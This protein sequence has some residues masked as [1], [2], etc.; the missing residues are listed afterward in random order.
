MTV[1]LDADCV[2]NALGTIK[3]IEIEDWKQPES[4]KYY[5]RFYH[6]ST[7]GTLC[8]EVSVENGT[9]KISA[10]YI[11]NLERQYEVDLSAIVN[12]CAV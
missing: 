9:H 5:A 8:F 7:N 2:F 10:L 4:K 11:K 6:G 1:Y 12:R 3:F